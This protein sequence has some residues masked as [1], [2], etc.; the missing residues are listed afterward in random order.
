VLAE[1]GFAL[2]EEEHRVGRAVEAGKIPRFVFGKEVRT[3]K[4]RPEKYRT[5]T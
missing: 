4:T 1:V 2:V 3:V 5:I